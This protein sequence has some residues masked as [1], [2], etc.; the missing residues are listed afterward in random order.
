MFFGIFFGLVF[1]IINF[2][3]RSS[4]FL[5]DLLENQADLIYN[6][7]LQNSHLRELLYKATNNNQNGDNPP[8]TSSSTATNRDTN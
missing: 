8:E 3:I 5:E 2:N 1:F 6:L 4:S 7:K